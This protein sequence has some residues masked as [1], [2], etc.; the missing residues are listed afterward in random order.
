MC[1]HVREGE[2]E[3]GRE[4]GRG[5]GKDGEIR[6][7]VHEENNNC[8]LSSFNAPL[9]CTQ[10]FPPSSLLPF[11]FPSSFLPPSLLLPHSFLSLSFPSSTSST[12]QLSW[13]PRIVEVIRDIAEY[14]GQLER[15]FVNYILATLCAIHKYHCTFW[16]D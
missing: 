8:E 4:G 9:Q 14:S 2:R 5:G 15:Q 10:P 11:S 7:K 6:L 1:A 3:R 12:M 16:A 13:R